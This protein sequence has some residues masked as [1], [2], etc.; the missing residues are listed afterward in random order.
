M[1]SLAALIGGL[2]LVPAVSA[3]QGAAAAAAPA[4][5]E[6]VLAGGALALCSSSSPGNCRAGAAPAGRIAESYRIDSGGRAR[7]AAVF[8]EDGALSA[9]LDR[10]AVELGDQG[11]DARTLEDAFAKHCEADCPWQ[12]FDDYQRMGLLAAFALPQ[13]DAEGRRLREVVSL[14]AS[15]ERGGVAVV[16]AFVAAARQRAGGATPRIAFVTASGFDP[17][18]AVDY[19]TSLLRE[20]GAEP[21]WWP[22]DAAFAATVAGDRD[23]TKL[24]ARQAK[25]LGLPDSTHRFTDHVAAQRAACA[26]EQAAALPAGLHG[27]FFAGGDQWRL[28]RAFVADDGTPYPWLQQLR[29]AFASGALV[30][31]GTSAGSAVQSARG[32]LGNG[33]PQRALAEGLHRV[34]PP[35]PGCARAGSCGGID[36]NSLTWWP[37]GGLGLAGPFLVDT[38][39]SERAR[40]WRLL[41]VLAE[42]V[43]EFGL[44][45]DETSAITLRGDGSRYTLRALGAQGGWL[46][47]ARARRCGEL[48]ASASYLAPGQTLS[49][50]AGELDLPQPREG[51]PM[52]PPDLDALPASA[53][54]FAPGAVRAGLPHLAADAPEWRLDAPGASLRLARRDDTVVLPGTATPS[55]LSVDV[56]LRYES[57]C[58]ATSG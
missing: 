52:T 8:G 6:L 12:R 37:E 47:A 21:Q 40:E 38:H 45:V 30:V 23:C 27:V 56:T 15:R 58:A 48:Q 35:T 9:L 50:T 14:A 29:E 49:W 41:R 36:E 18:D 26:A 28:R 11:V 57:R 19:Y 44:G 17:F 22:L 42:G 39:F 20:A 54:P 25:L 10:V 53:D 1:F 3:A 33:S 4:Q 46:F 2:S 43:A 32:M 5:A 13:Q 51:L 31:G 7:L 34:A 55:V 24:T 16:D